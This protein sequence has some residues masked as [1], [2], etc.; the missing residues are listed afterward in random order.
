MNVTT[1]KN[2]PTVSHSDS[3]FG[4][5]CTVARRCAVSWRAWYSILFTVLSGRELRLAPRF[6][7]FWYP[8]AGTARLLR[9]IR[10]FPT[11]TQHL[12]KPHA[13]STIHT[14]DAQKRFLHVSALC[15]CHPQGIFPVK[16]VPSKWS[17]VRSTV[18]HTHTHIHRVLPEL[19]YRLPL[20]NC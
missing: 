11:Y 3:G 9:N 15:W 1:L 16:F 14:T 7:A 2:F 20:D 10:A 12:N 19:Q 13:H 4:A 6:T 5:E 8:E 18:T 17:A